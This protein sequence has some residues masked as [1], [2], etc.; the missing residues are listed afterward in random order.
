[1]GDSTTLLKHDWT[2][3]GTFSTGA[4]TEE[5]VL[6]PVGTLRDDTPGHGYTSVYAKLKRQNL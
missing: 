6:V 5:D 1:M 2:V 3:V 4:F